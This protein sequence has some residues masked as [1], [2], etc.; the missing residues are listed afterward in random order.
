MGWTGTGLR[1]AFCSERWQNWRD[2]NLLPISSGHQKAGPQEAPPSPCQRVSGTKRYT[3]CFSTWHP[4]PAKTGG[5]RPL[6]LC[7]NERDVWWNGRR[8]EPER[9]VGS[10]Q[11]ALRSA[12]HTG[13]RWKNLGSL[14]LPGAPGSWAGPAAVLCLPPRAPFVSIS[15]C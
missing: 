6:L 7:E 5:K 4:L 14:R 10:Q 13:G 1:A 15:P 2:F 8:T 12:I 3:R 11:A 9:D